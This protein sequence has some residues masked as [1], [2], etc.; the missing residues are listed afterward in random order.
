[1]PDNRDSDFSSS[2]RLEFP[3]AQKVE[4][5]RGQGLRPVTAAA[6]SATSAVTTETGRPLGVTLIAL[7]EFVRAGV[8]LIGL[9]A[10]AMFR[11]TQASAATTMAS[12]AASLAMFF[13]VLWIA[14]AIA[15]GVCLWNRVNWGRRVLIATSCWSVYRIVRFQLLYSAAAS[16]ATESQMTRLSSAREVVYMMLAVN[17]LIGLY[18]AFAPG[19]AEAFGQTA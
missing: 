5:L 10:L 9:A 12:A 1:M 11:G 17:I 8:L 6:Q 19:V 13:L 18:L 7:Y 15:I 3:A 16:V 2:L 4:T 14:Y